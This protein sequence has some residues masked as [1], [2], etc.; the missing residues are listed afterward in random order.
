MEATEVEE[1]EVEVEATAEAM[2]TD[3]EAQMD[4]TALLDML[5]A[6][7]VVEEEELQSVSTF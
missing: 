4:Q 7:E 5:V 2:E 3:T 1:E 6:V